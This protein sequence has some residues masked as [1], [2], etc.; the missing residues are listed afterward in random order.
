MSYISPK[1]L[2]TRLLTLENFGHRL[3]L[4]GS[5]S[6]KTEKWLAGGHIFL[7]IEKWLA[8]STYFSLKLKNG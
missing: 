7:K 4:A 2:T 5:A 8:G 6:L 1:K 3:L